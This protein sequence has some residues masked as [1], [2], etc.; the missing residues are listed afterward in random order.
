M[1]LQ[2]GSGDSEGWLSDLRDL[3]AVL[4]R[5]ILKEESDV[6]ALAQAHFTTLEAADIAARFLEGKGRL[7][8]ENPLTMA[9]HAVRDMIS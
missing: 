9:A 8:M 3:R 7:A 2:M 1:K 6:F 4:Q 5:H